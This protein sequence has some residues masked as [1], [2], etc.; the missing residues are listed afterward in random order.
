M[1]YS[2]DKFAVCAYESFILKLTNYDEAQP[3]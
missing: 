2:N 1:F 3:S